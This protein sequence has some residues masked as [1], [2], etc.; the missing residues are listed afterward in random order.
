MNL[1]EKELKILSTCDIRLQ[2]IFK[3]VAKRFDI[4]I[5][6]GFR[7]EADQNK[8]FAE[9]KSKKKWPDGEHNQMPSKAVDVVPYP[10][11]W[12]DINRFILLSKV[13]LAIAKEQ[14]IK[15]KWGADWNGN[16]KIDDERFKDFPH[17]E[18]IS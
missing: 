12:N 14:G 1:S 10:V 13:V 6:C 11:D 7:N 15:L 17:W 5:L 4:K 3:E 2:T 16:G 18:I 9:G 8:A